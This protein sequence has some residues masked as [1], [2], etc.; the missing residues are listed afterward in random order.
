MAGCQTAPSQPA[1]AE[2][3]NSPRPRSISCPGRSSPSHLRQLPLAPRGP[4]ASRG[5]WGFGTVPRRL[6]SPRESNPSKVRE[7]FLTRLIAGRQIGAGAHLRRQ[8][9]GM[10]RST[11][12]Q[13]IKSYK[14]CE[15]ISSGYYYY[16]YIFFRE[17]TRSARLSWSPTFLYGVQPCQPQACRRHESGFA[18][19]SDTDSK[20]IR[21][22]KKN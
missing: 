7:E 4:A 14:K 12:E 11:R 21:L 1:P 22:Q 18:R 5:T 13:S 8:R 16:I 6:P 3:S 2:L 15:G 9:A 19:R 17:I 20:I 10:R